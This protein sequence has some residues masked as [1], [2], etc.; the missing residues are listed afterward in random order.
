MI[1][2]REVEYYNGA[3]TPPSCRACNLDM[4]N[5]TKCTGAAACLAC[6]SG[7]FVKKTDDGCIA[8]CSSDAAPSYLNELGTKCVASC[9][10]K[11]SIS[12]QCVEFCGSDEYAT[13][14]N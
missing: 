10:D 3:G 14:G 7:S 2:C 4:T 9:D 8:D 13:A 11:I 1:E 6:S 5:C 12:S